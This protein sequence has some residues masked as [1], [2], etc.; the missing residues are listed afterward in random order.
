MF[1]KYSSSF[2]KDFN[3]DYLLGKFEKKSFQNYSKGEFIYFE[4]E[5]VSNIYFV[6]SGG[7][8]LVKKGI[9]T[10]NGIISKYGKG[11]ILGL[12]DALL[13]KCYSGSA[14]VSSNANVLAICK[15]DF[16][17]ITGKNDEFNLWVLK[18]LSNKIVS[19]G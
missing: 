14:F 5:Q 8:V 12:E 1:E 15:D 11:D 3:F 17:K 7:I 10:S 6:L 9:D 18:Y 13:G 19:A 4:N 16:L 2:L